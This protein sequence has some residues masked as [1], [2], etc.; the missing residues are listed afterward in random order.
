MKTTNGSDRCCGNDRSQSHIRWL[1]DVRPPGRQ[2]RLTEGSFGRCR[3]GN[4][5][6]RSGIERMPRKN[7]ADRR[8]GEVASYPYELF[9]PCVGSRLQNQSAPLEY[10]FTLSMR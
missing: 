6:E 1:R 5:T 9:R 3:V 2:R 10:R 7:A 4:R 8:S